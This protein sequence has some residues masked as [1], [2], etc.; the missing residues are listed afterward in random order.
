MNLTTANIKSAVTGGEEVKAVR[1]VVK[2][3][4]VV[5]PADFRPKQVCIRLTERTSAQLASIQGLIASYGEGE[6]LAEL[7]EKVVLPALERFVEPFAEAARADRE[8]AAPATENGEE[9]RRG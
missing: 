7:F 4:S 3:R 2:P 1:H 9:A 5:R 8:R 6:T